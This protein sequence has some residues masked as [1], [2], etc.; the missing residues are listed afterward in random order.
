MADI[1][2]N[3]N[4]FR[5]ELEISVNKTKKLVEEKRFDGINISL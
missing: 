1:N 3:I 2:D 5:R 4:E